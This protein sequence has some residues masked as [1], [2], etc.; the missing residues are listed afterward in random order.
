MKTVRLITCND[1]MEAHIL[2]GAL[3]NEGIETLLNNENFSTLYSCVSNIAGVDLFVL[4][5]DY[6]RAVEILK[7]NKSWPEEV[8]LCPYCGSSD[9]KFHL[10]EGKRWRALGVAIVSVLTIAP[11]RCN[12][13]EYTCR[14]CNKTFEKPVFQS[15]SSKE[16]EE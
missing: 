5:K 2:Q 13:W 9:I 7:D 14:Q 3:K 4:E 10:K 6:D 16:K 1:P 15:F 11:P 12:Y 8:A